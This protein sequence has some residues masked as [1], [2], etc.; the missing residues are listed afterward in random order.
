MNGPKKT[1]ARTVAAVQ[2]FQ[3][4]LT[5]ANQK[6]QSNKKST[7]TEAQRQRILEALRVGPKTSYDL[8]R[9]GCYQCPARI[10]EL[11]G[12]GYFIR[13]ERVTLYDRDGFAHKGAARYHLESEPQQNVVLGTIAGIANG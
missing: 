11:R 1:K 8:R 12:R 5:E 4:T 13:M 7:A 10:F 9:M 6:S 3:K 2:G